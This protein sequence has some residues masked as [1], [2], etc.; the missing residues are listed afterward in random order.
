[1]PSWSTRAARST[2]APTE[3]RRRTHAWIVFCNDAV[4]P[5]SYRA[6]LALAGGR[7]GPAREVPLSELRAA[8]ARA[9]TEVAKRG[10]PWFLGGQL[11]LVD[12]AWAPFLR[13][14]IEAEGWGMPQESRLAAFPVLH[15]LAGRLLAHRS[16]AAAA[17]G[18]LGPRM[19]GLYAER[20]AR[21]G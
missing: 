18:D 11:T 15:A 8:L 20:A 10:G 4:M 9:E 5:A 2:S 21:G 16:V 7:Q 19:R 12:A 14:W 17:P 1:M 13:R 3:K 6:L